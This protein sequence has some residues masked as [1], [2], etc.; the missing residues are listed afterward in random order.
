MGRYYVALRTIDEAGNVSGL[1]NILHAC[2][3][4]VVANDPDCDGFSSAVESL[5]RNRPRSALH[6]DGIGNDEPPPDRWPVDFDD[7]QRVNS[8]D[9]GRYVPVMNAVSGDGRYAVRFDLDTNGRINTVD[10]G[11]FVP[12]S[13]RECRQ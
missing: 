5:H 13:N 8:I 1:S 11:K 12:Y 10:I 3:A 6:G 2:F 7:N 9:V 4:A